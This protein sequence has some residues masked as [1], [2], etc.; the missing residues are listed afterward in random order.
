MAGLLLIR[1]RRRLI[2]TEVRIRSFRQ[3]DQLLFRH[4]PLGNC[5]ESQDRYPA[6]QGT[7]AAP[8]GLRAVFLLGH[9]FGRTCLSDRYFN[10]LQSWQVYGLTISGPRNHE[11]RGGGSRECRNG[12]TVHA[13]S[14]QAE[15][16]S[17]IPEDLPL[18][19]R[20]ARLYPKA[21]A[22]PI[23]M[24]TLRR[25]GCSRWTDLGVHHGPK[26]ALTY[27]PDLFSDRAAPI[28]LARFS[29]TSASAKRFVFR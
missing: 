23:P 27:S 12:A 20:A 10:G 25:S 2:T 22:R 14:F 28:A 4:R 11:R 13:R 29:I 7:Q 15:H 24:F 17:G 26:P 8:G 5:L 16:P 21:A 19:R 6:I 3:V 1:P 18:C 9:H